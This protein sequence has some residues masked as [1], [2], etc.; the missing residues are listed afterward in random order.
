MRRVA[1]S[2]VSVAKGQS[3]EQNRREES[4]EEES[5]TG[6]LL[7]S[8]SPLSHSVWSMSYAPINES[9]DTQHLRLSSDIPLQSI[10]PTKKGKEREHRSEEE[11]EDSDRDEEDDQEGIALIGSV[12]RCEKAREVDQSRLTISE[13]DFELE[14]AIDM[15]KKVSS[16]PS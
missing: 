12:R 1:D 3:S 14:S 6:S 11:E 13:E 10:H 5:A 15:V 7:P 4:D 2:L 16:I 8:A 9:T